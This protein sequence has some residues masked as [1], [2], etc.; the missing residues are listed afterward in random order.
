MQDR[1]GE[2]HDSRGNGCEIKGGVEIEFGIAI[3]C[4]HLVHVHQRQTKSSQ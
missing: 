1:N 2:Q 3:D 4:G